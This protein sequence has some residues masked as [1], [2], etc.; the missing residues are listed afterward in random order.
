MAE[1]FFVEES[2]GPNWCYLSGHGI[3]PGWVLSTGWTYCGQAATLK[4]AQDLRDTLAARYKHLVF[5]VV[6]PYLPPLPRP[7]W[8]P[9]TMKAADNALRQMFAARC[10]D[11][12]YQARPLV[13]TASASKPNKGT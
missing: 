4:A 13:G 12:V 3:A 8:G 6:E 11:F 2:S 9:E 10:T 1:G 5:R 7:P